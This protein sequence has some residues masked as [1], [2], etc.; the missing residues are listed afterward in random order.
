MKTVP[1]P[2]IAPQPDAASQLQASGRKTTMRWLIPFLLVCLFLATLIWLPRQAQQMEASE[3]LEQLIADS[4]WVEQAIR[5]QLS[6]D[7][8]SMRIIGREISNGRLHQDHFRSRLN[9]LL[10]NNREFYRV[11]WFNAEGL[12]G[13]FNRMI[14]RSSRKD[15]LATL[16][17]DG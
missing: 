16:A 15:P 3:R 11:T 17:D 5:F 1:P 12:S 14:F 6:R 8:E 7:D 9:A 13:R 10:R 2:P 4:L